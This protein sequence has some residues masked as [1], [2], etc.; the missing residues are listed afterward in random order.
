MK[1]MNENIDFKAEE[2]DFQ[3]HKKHCLLLAFK[4]EVIAVE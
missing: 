2:A 3:K 1:V 4:T